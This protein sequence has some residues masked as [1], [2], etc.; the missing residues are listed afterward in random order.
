ML[1]EAPLATA[2]EATATGHRKEYLKTIQ[3]SPATGGH[4]NHDQ[5]MILPIITEMQFINTI[6]R[7][8]FRPRWLAVA[9]VRRL[10]DA[11]ARSD[12]WPG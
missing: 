4:K 9:I 5:A 1:N 7:A 2:T 8:L 3:Y 6:F 11:M 10:R 12:W